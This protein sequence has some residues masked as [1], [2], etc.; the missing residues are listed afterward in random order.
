M[1]LV[2]TSAISPIF[3]ASISPDVKLFAVL[4]LLLVIGVLYA[5]VV[6]HYLRQTD[7]RHSRK[8]KQDDGS[9][10]EDVPEK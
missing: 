10:A 5:I 8:R 2:I 9:G 7:T 4:P 3:H 1:N 6:G